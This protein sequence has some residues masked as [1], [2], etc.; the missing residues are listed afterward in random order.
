VT[1]YKVD[2]T[3]SF[4]IESDSSLHS[5]SAWAVQDFTRLLK[6]TGHDD[7]TITST[8]LEKPQMPNK[9]AIIEQERQSFKP[10]KGDI[11]WTRSDVSVPDHLQERARRFIEKLNLTESDNA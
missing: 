1:R 6:A 9:A 11:L 5:L 10:A 2:V 3:C 8:P 4:L 7:Y